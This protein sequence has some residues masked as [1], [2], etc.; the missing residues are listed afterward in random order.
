MYLENA[1]PM[2]LP[3]VPRKRENTARPR[4]PEAP[5]MTMVLDSITITKILRK[6]FESKVFQFSNLINST[7]SSKIVMKLRKEKKVEYC[8]KDLHKVIKYNNFTYLPFQII[9]FPNF[10]NK[11]VGF[12]LKFTPLNYSLASA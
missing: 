4:S 8:S 10:E 7:K 6:R 11:I 9:L 1:V 5:V 12:I 3:A 2:T